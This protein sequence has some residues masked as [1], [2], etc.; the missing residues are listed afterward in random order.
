MKSVWKEDLLNLAA[1]NSDE[2]E[3]VDLQLEKYENLLA[4]DNEVASWD[5]AYSVNSLVYL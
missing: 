2:I 3:E 5:Q 1:W 4:A